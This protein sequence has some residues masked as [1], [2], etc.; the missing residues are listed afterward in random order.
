MGIQVS[1][2]EGDNEN[3]W[4]GQWFSLSDRL[5][6]QL[7]RAYHITHSGNDSIWESQRSV[8]Y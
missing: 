5:E 4:L 8:D 1:D 7:V 6:L 2:K 3:H